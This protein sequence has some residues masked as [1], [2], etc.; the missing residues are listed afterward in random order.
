MT[1]SFVMNNILRYEGRAAFAMVGLTAGGVLNIFG[2]WFLMTRLHMGVAGAGL[3]TAL[4]Q[5]VSFLLLLTAFLRGRTQSRIS[6]RRVP[7]GMKEI[8]LICSTGFPSLL[9]QGLGSLATMILNGRAGIYGDAAVAAMSIVNRICFLLFAVGLGIGQGF[10]PVSAFN[11]GAR[12]YSRVRSSFLFTWGASEVCL[13]CLA[14]AGMIF[15]GSLIGL[16][17]NDPE[18]IRIGTYA[19][20]AQLI[21]LFFQPLLVCSNMLLQSTGQN[22]PA[23]FLSA[24]RSGLCFIPVVLILSRLMG[25]NGVA[26]SQAVADVLAFLIAIPFPIRFLRALPEDG[27]ETA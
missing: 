10:Q 21:A 3:S 6:L 4:S 25:M 24:L 12:K 18:V 17:R 16:F 5:G 7:R 11:Y 27:A 13:G 26:I 1:A 14:V 23:S 15:S 19:L 8:R 2:D 9:R 22:G 20:R